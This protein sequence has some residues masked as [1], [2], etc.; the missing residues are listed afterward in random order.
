MS[1]K[2]N[3]NKKSDNISSSNLPTGQNRQ[4][5]SRMDAINKLL[6]EA[7]PQPTGNDGDWWRNISAGDFAYNVK[8][9]TG[10]P[11][12]S[13]SYY[14]AF[15]YFSCLAYHPHEVQ[16]VG[17]ETS[18]WFR[19]YVNSFEKLSQN[20]LSDTMS[21][22]G[23]PV[24]WINPVIGTFKGYDLVK[25]GEG[26]RAVLISRKEELPFIPVTR[27]QYLDYSIRRINQTFDGIIKNLKELPVDET[28]KPFREEN[29]AAEIKL[30]N[31]NL[32]RYQRELE[33]TTTDGLLDSPAIVQQMHPVSDDWPIFATGEDGGKMLITDNPSYIRKDLPKYIPQ[34]MVVFW[35]WNDDGQGNYYRKMLE[36][37]FPIEKLQAMID[38]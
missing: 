22:N 7:Y 34:F 38:K 19:V 15:G 3:W 24:H 28:E 25:C 37:N 21:V 18:T 35:S 8:T 30:K 36:A 33:K 14:C 31:H 13:Y 29:I 17:G 9:N 6:Q 11:V 12:C 27:K 16:V 10:I 23:L 4:A 5:L 26:A 32:K 1:I 20:L 2:G